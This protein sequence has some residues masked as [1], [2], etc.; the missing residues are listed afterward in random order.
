MPP[1]ED[2]EEAVSRKIIGFIVTLQVSSIVTQVGNG[3]ES[4]ENLV[5]FSDRTMPGIGK[6]VTTVVAETAELL[7]PKVNPC[8]S[9]LPMRKSRITIL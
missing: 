3:R 8:I 7:L 5:I 2:G 1:V 6:T 4:L 9:S